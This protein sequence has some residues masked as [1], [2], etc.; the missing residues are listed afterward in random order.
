MGKH[1]LSINKALDDKQKDALVAE[2]Q[3][4]NQH[5]TDTN[6]QL[7][8]I[9]LK[10]KIQLQNKEKFSLLEKQERKRRTIQ[11]MG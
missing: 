9:E 2:I 5:K 10:I 11:S 4:A 1:Q 3:Q 6:N 8:D 7:L